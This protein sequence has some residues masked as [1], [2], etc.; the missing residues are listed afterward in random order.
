MRGP[1][2]PDFGGDWRMPSDAVATL[3][4]QELDDLS[5][6][7]FSISTL[8]RMPCRIRDTTLSQR[9]ESLF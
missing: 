1:K 5:T 7:K 8:S 4:Q 6:Q 9:Y 2:V 3:W